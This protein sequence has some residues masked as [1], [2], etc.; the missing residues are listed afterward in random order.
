MEQMKRVG[1]YYITAERKPIES[2]WDS[3]PPAQLHLARVLDQ[4]GAMV[5]AFNGTATAFDFDTLEIDENRQDWLD[6]PTL[7]QDT[8]QQSFDCWALEVRVARWTI[9]GGAADGTTARVVAVLGTGGPHVEVDISCDHVGR[10]ESIEL[11]RYW[12]QSDRARS[13]DS[14]TL[15]TVADFLNTFLGGDA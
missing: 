5:R 3:M 4:M 9:G 8:A 1:E 6:G 15:D 7:Q 2:H 12:S 10:P 14:G 13:T 11:R